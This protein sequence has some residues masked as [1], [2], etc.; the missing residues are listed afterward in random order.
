M[1]PARTAPSLAPPSLPIVVLPTGLVGPEVGH[2]TDWT[3][4]TGGQSSGT[5]VP[6]LQPGDPDYD[7]LHDDDVVLECYRRCMVLHPHS[8]CFWLN[9]PSGGSAYW[10]NGFP[11]GGELCGC[12]STTSRSAK[13]FCR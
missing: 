8:S 3:Y 7:A 12:S 10:D 5:N 11:V 1:V 6:P 4:V 9:V 2:C 13:T